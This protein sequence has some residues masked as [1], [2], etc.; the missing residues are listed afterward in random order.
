MEAIREIE[1]KV[2]SGNLFLAINNHKY[3][4]NDDLFFPCAKIT[5][6]LYVIKTVLRWNMIERRMTEVKHVF[7]R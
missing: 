6:N 3:I 7:E 2:K 5:P 1:K 4:K